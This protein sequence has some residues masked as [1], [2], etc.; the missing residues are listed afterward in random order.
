MSAGADRLDGPALEVRGRITI[1]EELLADAV[2]AACRKAERI[3]SAA[4][5]RLGHVVSVAE[6]DD[7]VVYGRHRSAMSVGGGWD[8]PE[9]EP[10]DARIAATVQVV[11]TLED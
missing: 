5:R 11:F 4:G 6:D 9:L 3:A 2:A 10:S 1:A 8:G 7:G